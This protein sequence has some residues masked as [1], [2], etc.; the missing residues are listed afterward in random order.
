MTNGRP[1]PS[2]REC[3]AFPL[4]SPEARRDVL[5]GGALLF[6]PLIGWVL[7][8]GHRLE[9]VRR[10]YHHDPP[11]YRGFAPW[12]RTLLRGA[13]AF[14][15]I[16]VYLSPA[17]AAAGLAA[18]AWRGEARGLAAGA[19]AVALGCFALGVFSLPGG[20]TYNAVTGD[21]R[22][23]YRPD[24]AFRRAREGGRAYL[25][26]WGIAIAAIGLSFLGLAALGVGFFYTSVWAWSVVGYAF[27]KAL[28]LA[29]PAAP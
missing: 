7:N 23:L 8:L 10:V 3:F 17:A 5:T 2:L 22:Y 16:V 27:S 18:L 13:K 28:A 9:V 1:L 12:G 6:L 4:S 21:I 11:Y 29:A 14:T 20:M 19:G 15:A 24:E 25:T 26:A